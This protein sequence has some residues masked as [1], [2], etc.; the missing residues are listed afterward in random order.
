MIDCVPSGN[1][2]EPAALINVYP[3]SDLG[4]HSS[5]WSIVMTTKGIINVVKYVS[6]GAPGSVERR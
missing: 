4:H 6:D 2:C 3:W 5:L 1:V